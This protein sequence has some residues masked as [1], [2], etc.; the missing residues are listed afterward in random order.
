[1]YI[2]D[3]VFKDLSAF[4]GI[5]LINPLSKSSILGITE[6]DVGDF[7]LALRIAGLELRRK[8]LGKTA[9]ASLQETQFRNLEQGV[10]PGIV[11]VMGQERAESLISLCREMAGGSKSRIIN[12]K[13][14]EP[15][16]GTQGRGLQQL[17]AKI[18]KMAVFHNDL[19]YITKQAVSIDQSV[20]KG[21]RKTHKGDENALGIIN[22]AFEGIE[23]PTKKLASVANPEDTVW[24]MWRFLN[25]KTTHH[26]TLLCNSLTK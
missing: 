25:S 1:V 9:L 13:T 3:E 21:L 16:E 14:G 24:D 22:G 5:T 18:I 2:V 7:R 26:V 4:Y 20:W 6:Y 15:I 19:E 17:A 10:G 12:I 23:E 8:I 11:A